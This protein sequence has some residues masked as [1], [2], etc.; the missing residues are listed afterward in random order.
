MERKMTTGFKSFS[1]Q[2]YSAAT[3]SIKAAN[4][5]TETNPKPSTEP[6]KTV[7]PNKEEP[8]VK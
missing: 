7:E 3:P 4:E 2:V 8:K 1:K 5:P 6:E